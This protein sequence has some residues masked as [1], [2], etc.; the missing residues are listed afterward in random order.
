MQHYCR[1][2]HIIARCLQTWT[3]DPDERYN[4]QYLLRGWPWQRTCRHNLSSW[5]NFDLWNDIVCEYR[6]SVSSLLLSEC[7]N[8]TI[9][10]IQS[11]I[12]LTS[13]FNSKPALEAAACHVRKRDLHKVCHDLNETMNALHLALL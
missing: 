9:P 13:G 12:T 11:K 6:D 8:R 5:F 1:S 4:K 3:T 2:F 10:I 7:T